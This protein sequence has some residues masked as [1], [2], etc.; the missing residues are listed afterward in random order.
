MTYGNHGK[1]KLS[2]FF[3]DTWS[4]P[5]CTFLQQL[6]IVR[7]QVMTKEFHLRL[8]NSFTAERFLSPLKDA[9][10]SMNTAFSIKLTMH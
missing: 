5:G 7:V 9:R 4:A 3:D 6:L 1:N 8:D 2:A 10:I